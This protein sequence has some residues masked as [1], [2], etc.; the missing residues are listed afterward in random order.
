MDAKG[1]ENHHSLLPNCFS[2]KCVL[3]DTKITT[4]LEI[5][6]CFFFFNKN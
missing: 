1:G 6:C 4:R 5:E 3:H 2:Q